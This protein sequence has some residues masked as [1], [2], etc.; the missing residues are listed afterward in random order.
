MTRLV[1]LM[2]LA[3]TDELRHNRYCSLSH[4]SGSKGKI[5][6]GVRDFVKGR[7]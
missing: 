7:N 2:I 3:T 5:D 1:S 4:H 6:D